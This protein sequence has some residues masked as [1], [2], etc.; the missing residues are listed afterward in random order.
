M[1]NRFFTAL[2]TAELGVDRKDPVAMADVRT[3][4]CD[5][6][7]A[8]SLQRT[9]ACWVHPAN[10]LDYSPEAYKRA[11]DSGADPDHLDELWTQAGFGVPRDTQILTKIGPYPPSRPKD[12]RTHIWSWCRLCG[13]YACHL[14]ERGSMENYCQ[15]QDHKRDGC[16]PTLLAASQ[17]AA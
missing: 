14:E 7:T 17:G 2:L 9:E 4:M 6:R 1:T 16:E 5:L 3:S 10:G 12:S 15:T 11:L 13:W 8:L